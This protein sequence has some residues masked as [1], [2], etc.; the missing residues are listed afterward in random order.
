VCNGYLVATYRDDGYETGGTIGMVRTATSDPQFQAASKKS[1]TFTHALAVAGQY[2]SA[3]N[4]SNPAYSVKVWTYCPT[5]HPE[6][7]PSSS[8]NLLVGIA[9]NFWNYSDTMK[10]AQ[11]YKPRFFTVP[12]PA[13]W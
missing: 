3:G 9:W 4:V 8:A 5:L 7:A 12:A 1:K 13:Y 2:T 6:L 11:A 10:N